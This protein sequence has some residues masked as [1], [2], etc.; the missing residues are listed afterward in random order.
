EIGVPHC[1]AIDRRIVERRQAERRHDIT[2]DHPAACSEQRHGLD[3]RNRL[4]TLVDQA[5]GIRDREKRPGERKAIVGQLRHQAIPARASAA[6]SGTARLIRISTMPS[7]SLRS[8]TGAGAFGRATS[9]AIATIAGSFGASSGMPTA[10][11][12]TSSFGCGSL[13]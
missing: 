2:R 11:R 7:T 6:A 13:L 5:L 3:L 4:D 9:D 8:R 12:W 10:A 1:V